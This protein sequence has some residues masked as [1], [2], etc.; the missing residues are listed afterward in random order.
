MV[1]KWYYIGSQNEKMVVGGEKMLPGGTGIWSQLFRYC[2]KGYSQKVFVRDS[3]LNLLVALKHQ[4]WWLKQ[5]VLNWCLFQLRCGLAHQKLAQ[6]G[7]GSKSGQG[8]DIE[9]GKES[10]RSRTLFA[11]EDKL[12]VSAG[13]AM[14]RALRKIVA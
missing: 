13:K 14:A 8:G 6:L 11:P 3:H 2:S 1:C 4:T 7:L 9:N 12:G 5:S 10:C